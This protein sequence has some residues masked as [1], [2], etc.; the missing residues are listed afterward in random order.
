[1]GGINGKGN[2]GGIMGNETWVAL[3]AMKHGWH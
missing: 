2:M 1:M 3:G